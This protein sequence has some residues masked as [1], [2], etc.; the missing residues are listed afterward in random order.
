MATSWSRHAHHFLCDLERLGRK[1][2]PEDT[3]HEIKGLVRQLLQI[4]RI[5]FLKLK[6]VQSM[7]RSPPVPSLDQ[8]PR[9]IHAQH[10]CAEFGR[11]QCRRA[12]AAAE[13]QYLESL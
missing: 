5:P 3:D 2:R 9:D 1:H 7:L 6:V 8:V 12:I 10:I 4:G 13:I 11:G